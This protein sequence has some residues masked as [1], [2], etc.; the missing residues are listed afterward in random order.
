M[1]P[2]ANNFKVLGFLRA[3]LGLR[4]GLLGGKR[5]VSRFAPF[6]SMERRREY[7]DIKK[8]PQDAQ[9]Y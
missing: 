2:N 6:T 9:K 1:S 7:A 8:P 3:S 4:G 5:G